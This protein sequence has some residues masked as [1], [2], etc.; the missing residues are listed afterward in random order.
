M[1][2]LF[3][4]KKTLNLFALLLFLTALS[5]SISHAGL[6]SDPIKSAAGF[7]PS[8]LMVVIPATSH[9][10]EEWESF[11][12]KFK[13]HPK[14]K[15]YAWLFI[16]HDIGFT[17]L[18][19]VRDIAQSISVC[20][21]QVVST[22]KYEYVSL[23]GHSIGGMIARRAYLEAAGQFSDYSKA[24]TEWASKVDRILLF[25]SVNRGIPNGMHWWARLANWF[26]R[27]VPHPRFIL[28]DMAYGSD[29]VV[30]TRISWVRYFAKLAR[31]KKPTPR[32]VQFWG[33]QDS[34]VNEK[35]NADLEAF[36]GNV[37]ERVADAKHADLIRFEPEYTSVPKQRWKLFEKELFS[38]K[39]EELSNH[40]YHG[41]SRILII[42]NGIRDSTN[43]EWVI[44]LKNQA[45]KVYGEK[46][47][48]APDY[49]YFTAAHFAF[50]PLREKNIPK[51]RDLYSELVAAN[52]LAEFDFIGH[53]NGTYILANSLKSTPSMKFNNV[54]LVA[55]VI[56][57]EY[58]WA[59][60]FKRG[61]IK[62]LR[63]DVAT[64]D[65][66]VGILCAAL[67]ALGS[68]EVGP[69]G[70][71][72]FKGNSDKMARSKLEKVGW[73]DG[74]HSIALHPNNREHLL[75][76]VQTGAHFDSGLDLKSEVGWMRIVTNATQYLVWAMVLGLLWWMFKAGR[77]KALK[78]VG[79]SC[80]AILVAYVVL[81]I[82]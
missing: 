58:D 37:L 65:W 80:F 31:D 44:D 22:G 63:Y 15:E 75:E 3:Q 13:E 41:S 50:S 66:P 24:H 4:N 33:D 73:F 68:S 48:E 64:E 27:S 25:A 18:G 82:I 60:I 40:T 1:S 54:S 38:D 34:V 26:L 70:V 8:K 16:N 77:S 12:I 43:S 7:E 62:S 30:D 28:E 52:P 59:N 20:I 45:T 69:S 9:T 53:S 6:C 2:A 79:I 39:P 67:N 49:G 10:R 42:L 17:S 46:S 21:N 23:I 72:L 78:R 76:F 81:D 19:N 51:F 32:V 35:D 56:S 74:G 71:T 11:Y 29:F 47:V 61:Q 55:P 5:P 14:S 36:S 57:D